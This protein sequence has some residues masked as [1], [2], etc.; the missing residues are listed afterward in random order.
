MSP[1][2]SQEDDYEI[3]NE[4]VHF[5]SNEVSRM[6]DL[7]VR[8]DE[9]KLV[10]NVALD[11][12]SDSSQVEEAKECLKSFSGRLDFKASVLIGHSFGGA[13]TL[14]NLSRDHRLGSQLL[15]MLLSFITAW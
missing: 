11:N 1:S 6:M 8:I 3:R 4:Q 10:K 2:G 14:L 12:Q 15:L 5:R 9:G 13:T 7:M